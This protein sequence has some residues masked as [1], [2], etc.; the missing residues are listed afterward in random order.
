HQRT[1]RERTTVDH[2]MPLGCSPDQQRYR[3]RIDHSAEAETRDQNACNGRAHFARSN[4][5]DR[6]VG[7][8]T[9][10][11]NG[12][13]EYGRET[14]L[15]PWVS[16]YAAKTVERSGKLKPGGLW[17]DRAPKG[18]ERHDCDAQAECAQYD[19]DA[20]PIDEDG[21]ESGDGCT[22]EVAGQA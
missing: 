21:N 10:D 6:H 18:E 5:Q 8:Q 17:F 16:E 22:Q 14:D 11:E 12:F 9:V 20:A 19:E 4:Q 7:K 3:E 15:R 13:H 1:G 2:E